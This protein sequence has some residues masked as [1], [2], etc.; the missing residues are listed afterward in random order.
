ME[1]ENN[2]ANPTSEFPP[3]RNEENEVKMMRLK[4]YGCGIRVVDWVSTLGW[5]GLALSVL[6]ILGSILMMLRVLKWGCG[7]DINCNIVTVVTGV[8]SLI[9]SSLWLLFSARLLKYNQNVHSDELKELVKTGCSMIACIQGFCGGY[10]FTANT[11]SLVKL[12]DSE[13]IPMETLT[14]DIICILGSL[15]LII[16]SSLLI[17]GVLRKKT[18]PVHAF[19]IFSLFLECFLIINF[20]M[21]INSSRELFSS[22][23]GLIVTLIHLSYSNG[24]II[25]Q[26][27]ILLHDMGFYKK[28]LEFF[29]RTFQMQV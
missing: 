15:A 12:F 13:V 29:N 11:V 2:P 24:L 28:N 26:Y 20:S 23:F 6:T 18:E 27:N 8:I 5:Y 9:F 10:I 4:K 14:A 3:G 25:L 7:S 21:D 1:A 17:Y 19:F 22:I 16:F